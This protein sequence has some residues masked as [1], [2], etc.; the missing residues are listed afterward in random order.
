M[1]K[2]NDISVLFV[3]FFALLVPVAAREKQALVVLPHHQLMAKRAAELDAYRNMAERILGFSINSDT[4]VRDFVGESDNIAI[5]IDHFIKGIKIDDSQ[6]VWYDDGSCE[7]VAKVKLSEVVKQLKTSNDKYYQGKKYSTTDF[8]SIYASTTEKEIIV[9]GSAAIRPDSY[10]TQIQN[11]NII[12]PMM[13]SRS[14]IQTL[15][16][17]WNQHSARQRLQARRVATADAYRKLA[18]QLYGLRLT[19]KTTVKDFVESNDIIGTTMGAYLKGVRIDEVRYQNDGIVEVQVSVTVSQVIKTLKTVCDQYYDGSE[20]T[21]KDFEEIQRS[22]NRRIITVLGMGAVTDEYKDNMIYD[23]EI[24][25]N[26]IKTSTTLIEE[27][28]EVIEIL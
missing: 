13:N 6:T 20:W 24:F 12:M 28:A 7:V 5:D 8:E 2:K 4:K 18:E 21:T 26:R 10:I 23:S 25:K 1:V 11:Y 15:P 17:V 9:Y 22:T 3:V 27:T 19:A 16:T 14:K